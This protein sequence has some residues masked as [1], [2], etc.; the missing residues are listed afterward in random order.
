M[1][2]SFESHG[3][4]IQCFNDGH[5]P[6]TF[7]F[8][9]HQDESSSV[10]PKIVKYDGASLPNRSEVHVYD[11]VLHPHHAK[12]LYNVTAGSLPN[13]GSRNCT[14][15]K[16]DRGIERCIDIMKGDSPWGTYVTIE[17]ACKWVEWKQ[18]TGS[19]VESARSDY[20]SYLSN[21]ELDII[22]F[23]AWQENKQPSTRHRTEAL[24]MTV[25]RIRHALAVQAVARFFLQT[26][27]SHPGPTAVTLA[28]DP[29]SRHETLYQ[30]N[31]FRELAHGVA[32]WALSS[33]PGHSVQYHID[34]AELLRYEYNVTVPPLWAGTIQCSD[35]TNY[36]ETKEDAIT[37]VEA[38]WD[39][40]HECCGHCRHKKP[41]IKKHVYARNIHPHKPL[42]CT[43]DGI[44][45]CGAICERPQ[46]ASEKIT[47][48][49]CFME[50]G[51]FCVNLR[52]LEHYSEH[53]YK[54]N[55]SGDAF[56]GW[57]RPIYQHCKRGKL[58]RDHNSQWVTVPYVFNRGIVHKGDLPHLS[59]P[60]K[61]IGANTSLNKCRNSEIHRKSSPSRVIVG[62]NVFG[63]DVG[64]VISHAPEHSRAFRRKVKLYRATVGACTSEKFN[65]ANDDNVTRSTSGLNYSQIRQ[66]KV[67]TKLLVLAKRE[68]VKRDFRDLEERLVEGLWRRLLERKQ[69][70]DPSLLRV[71]ALIRGF[72]NI[73]VKFG[74]VDSSLTMDDIHVQLHHLVISKAVYCDC[75]GIA[76]IKG[77]RYTM[78]ARLE[79]VDSAE[80]Y[81]SKALISS[82]ALLDIE[83]CD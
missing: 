42:R 23:Y 32:V 62:F 66:N 45:E 17:E 30:I 51:E 2:P 4:R 10:I 52:G 20:D 1:R 81:N 13:R 55:I 44:H 39:G 53:G 58:F 27:P 76:G 25:D 59:A 50:G 6:E 29:P 35:L 57:K 48:H 18:T 43:V 11:N 72:D 14:D 41:I 7:R 34:Y 5:V 71:G 8:H 68:K 31:H 78:I 77:A 75:D 49:Q 79:G 69:S 21:W 80:L 65:K 56:G 22:N 26:I 82:S 12:M 67:L 60:I 47:K 37:S 28:P 19:G 83:V 46:R 74:C 73:G 24:P 40:V 16:S 54:G 70:E 3:G 61:H 33:H 36:V 64:E 63:H 9:T 38:Q 15:D